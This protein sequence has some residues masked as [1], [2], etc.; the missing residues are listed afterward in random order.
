VPAGH[1]GVARRRL[2]PAGDQARA[3]GLAQP[4]GGAVAII[5][6]F[7]GALHLNVHIHALVL[8]S[9]FARDASG[10]VGV[11]PAR[12]LTTLDVAEVLAAGEPRLRRLLEGAGLREDAHGGDPEDAGVDPWVDDAPALAGLAAASV[13]GVVALGRQSGARVR[14]LGHARAPP[15]RAQSAR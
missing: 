8:D 2:P 13:Q 6:R 3:V 1:G 7:G 9:V 11:H 5:Q 14:R 15:Q 10:A 4:H 12:R